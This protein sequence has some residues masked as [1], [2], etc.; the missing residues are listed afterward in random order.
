MSHFGLKT[1][2]AVIAGAGVALG[3]LALTSDKNA[4]PNAAGSYM[5]TSDVA[6]TPIPN[7]LDSKDSINVRVVDYSLPGNAEGAYTKVIYQMSTG[8][9]QYGFINV[10]NKDTGH[11]DSYKVKPQQGGYDTT[12]NGSPVSQD[13]NNFAI[14]RV[15]Q[16]TDMCRTTMPSANALFAKFQAKRTAAM[17]FARSAPN[18]TVGV[19]DRID[20]RSPEAGVSNTSETPRY[21]G[22]MQAQMNALIANIARRNT[23]LDRPG[24]NRL[25]AR[26]AATAPRR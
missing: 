15:E 6:C 20:V 26:V 21:I 14:F 3:Y 23:R 8:N 9:F 7:A 1:S 25:F 5:A 16:L 24:F 2:A 17:D 4:V 12:L 10:R 22:G 19:D 18:V 13:E 11:I